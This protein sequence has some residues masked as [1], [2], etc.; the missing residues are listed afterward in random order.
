[1]RR[2]RVLVLNFRQR[3]HVP[4]VLP[5]LL[6]RWTRTVLWEGLVRLSGVPEE[7]GLPHPGQRSGSS[8]KEGPRLVGRHSAPT[9]TSSARGCRFGG[10]K[11]SWRCPAP[12]V[13][14]CQEVQLEST[15][16]PEAP[17]QALR[18]R[19]YEVLFPP[20]D[21]EPREIRREALCAVLAPIDPGLHVDRTID[22]GVLDLVGDST[23]QPG[24]LVLEGSALPK[25]E[26]RAIL[27]ARVVQRSTG[28]ADDIGAKLASL[29]RSLRRWFMMSRPRKA[30]SEFRWLRAQTLLEEHASAG[31]GGHAAP[32]ACRHR[33]AE[34]PPWSRA[35]DHGAGAK[36]GRSGWIP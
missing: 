10:F 30:S 17:L 9:L 21:K 18:H 13:C 5:A 33:G 8:G 14:R 3:F 31:E 32:A 4:T 7:R 19:Y 24:N 1:M 27:A 11:R 29:T 25:P 26:S 28:S 22:A 20:R 6:E 35:Q 16:D 34:P 23:K 12:G 15:D 36:S 2:H